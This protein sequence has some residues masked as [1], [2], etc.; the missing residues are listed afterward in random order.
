MII[1]TLAGFGKTVED[2]SETLT[3]D[4]ETIKKSHSDMK[5]TIDEIEN[6]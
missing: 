2:I 3:K 1:Q 5:N 6:N 4:M